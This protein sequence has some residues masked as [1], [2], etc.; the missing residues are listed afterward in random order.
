MLC[1]KYILLHFYSMLCQYKN[2]WNWLPTCEDFIV[3]WGRQTAVSATA[4]VTTHVGGRGDD[5]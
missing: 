3:G 5:A 1:L 4:S 2:E